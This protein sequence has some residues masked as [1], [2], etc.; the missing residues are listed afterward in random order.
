MNKKVTQF[1]E[2]FWKAIDELIA[3]NKIII[4]RPKRTAHPRFPN[5][6]YPVDYGY[7]EGTTAMDGNG[8]YVWVGTQ[9]N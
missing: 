1:D 7:L 5:Y 3:A 9:R 2:Q 4:E 6:F 8:I